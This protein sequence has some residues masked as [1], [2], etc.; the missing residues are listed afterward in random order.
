MHNLNRRPRQLGK[1]SFPPFNP[2][3]VLDIPR[4][5]DFNKELESLSKLWK[6]I[7]MTR[8]PTTEDLINPDTTEETRRMIGKFAPN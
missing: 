2:D 1:N 3:K 7:G 6:I 5:R 4:P 8:K